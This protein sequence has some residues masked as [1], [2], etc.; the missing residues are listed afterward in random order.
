MSQ[1]A[2]EIEASSDGLSEADR[3]AP[4]E[5]SIRL[6]HLTTVPESLRFLSGQARHMRDWGIETHALS[7]PGDELGSFAAR[8]GVHAHG[9]QMA[10]RITPIRDLL[11]IYRICRVLRSVRPRIV[12]AHTPKAGVLGMVAARIGGFRCASITST[13][14]AS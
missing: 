6:L 11:A 14:C 1:V 5:A 13:A 9:V 10:R 8:E 7:S 2:P 4:A 3:P 12:H